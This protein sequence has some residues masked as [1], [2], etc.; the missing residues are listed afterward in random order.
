NQARE[1]APS[2][3]TKVAKPPAQRNH[4]NELEVAVTALNVVLSEIPRDSLVAVYDQPTYA[5]G[6]HRAIA[7]VTEAINQL[8]GGPRFCSMD[9]TAVDFQMQQSVDGRVLNPNLPAIFPAEYYSTLPDGRVLGHIALGVLRPADLT[10]N[11]PHAYF[12]DSWRESRA[13]FQPILGIPESDGLHNTSSVVHETAYQNNG[14]AC[15]IHVVLNGWAIALGLTLVP[16]PRTTDPFYQQAAKIINGAVYGQI[17][18][19]VIED[20][21]RC[22]GFVTDAAVPEELKFQ[23]TIAFQ[24]DTAHNDFMDRV[25]TAQQSV[26]NATVATQHS[27]SPA[28]PANGASEQ[29][30]AGNPGG[31]PITSTET[32]ATEQAEIDAAILRS[33]QDVN[34]PT[35]QPDLE[36]T[37]TTNTGAETGASPSS[38]STGALAETIGGAVGQQDGEVDEL[39]GNAVGDNGASQINDVDAPLP[40]APVQST[41]VDQGVREAS[42]ETAASLAEL[43]GKDSIAQPDA[44]TQDAAATATAAPVETA[45]EPATESTS[46]P[47]V[48]TA[49]SA[50]TSSADQPMTSPELEVLIRDFSP[51]PSPP[52]AS[53]DPDLQEEPQVP[54]TTVPEINV[55]N[56]EEATAAQ[57]MA[58]PELVSP[59]DVGAS[60]ARW[61]PFLTP[62]RSSEGSDGGWSGADW[63]FES[64]GDR[65]N[66]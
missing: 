55:I 28:A 61:A 25:T 30:N 53:T 62:P 6:V 31:Q 14:K 39:S 38:G 23:S 66:E 33:L 20:F 11:H 15:G 59:R 29:P 3:K 56:T 45:T 7:S 41:A 4:C 43:S 50:P 2:K 40:E 12:Y 34:V 18:A 19:E 51:F 65:K 57:P 46:A 5:T 10:S 49:A 22:K 9:W 58:S 47:T 13:R 36:V 35:S 26:V 42:A 24:D 60:A 44:S 37:A 17:G 1:E 48:D 63:G 21:F 16:N 64:L 54:Q 8:P 27:L 32:E 52:S